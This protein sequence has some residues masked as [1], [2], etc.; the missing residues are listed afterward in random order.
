MPPKTIIVDYQGLLIEYYS[1][2]K[3]SEPLYTEDNKPVPRFQ[4]GIRNFLDYALPKLLNLAES[5]LNII[6]VEDRGSSFRRAMYPGYKQRGV[7]EPVRSEQIGL[8]REKAKDILLS[9]G[10]TF[11]SVPNAEADDVIAML[12]DRLKG[13]KQVITVDKDL[14]QLVRPGVKVIRKWESVSNLPIKDTELLLPPKWVALF[15]SLVGDTSDTYPGIKGFGLKAFQ[16][17]VMEFAPHEIDDLKH[18]VSTP[19]RY[20]LQAL[21]VKEVEGT[22]RHKALTLFTVN[23]DAWVLMYRLAK[24]YPETGLDNLRPPQ[25]S[26]SM[27]T[28]ENI[29]QA[30]TDAKIPYMAQKYID[31]FAIQRT[32]VTQENLS[33]CLEDIESLIPMSPCVPWDY[34]TT[35]VDK[36]YAN[37]KGKKKFVDTLNSKITGVSFAFGQ[38]LNKSYYFPIKHKDTRNVPEDL[39]PALLETVGDMGIELVAHNTSFE[40]TVSLCQLGIQLPSY[41]DTALFAHGADENNFVGLKALSLRYLKYKQASYDSL[42]GGQESDVEEEEDIT[43][44]NMED[45][46]G[47]QVLNYGCDDSLVTGRLKILF[48]F[49]AQVEGWYDHVQDNEPLAAAALAEITYSGIRID[50]DEM[51]KQANDDRAL[52]AYCETKLA[53]LLKDNLT[54][55]STDGLERY[56][57]DQRN[58]CKVKDSRAREKGKSSNSLSLLRDKLVPYCSYTPPHTN[59]IPY[60]FAYTPARLKVVTE[61]LG[62]PPIEKTTIKWVSSYLADL[63]SLSDTQGEFVTSL[64]NHI[65]SESPE[66]SIKDLEAIC[67]KHMAHLDKSEILGTQIEL[68]SNTF[69][70]ALLYVML[71][72]P[73]RVRAKVDQGT[74]RRQYGLEGSPSIDKSAVGFA[75]TLDC[76]DAPWKKEVLQT[77]AKYQKAAT[78]ISNYWESWQTWMQNGDCLHPYFRRFGTVTR[79]PSSQNPNFNSIDK[80]GDVRRAVIPPFDGWVVSSIDFS[81]QELRRLA[82]RCLDPNLVAG[83]NGLP[84]IDPHSF[85]ACNIAVHRLAI[86]SVVT[87]EDLVLT[88]DGL[89]DYDWF[90]ATRK[91]E[92]SV[93]GGYLEASRGV[94]KI[95]NFGIA[96]GVTAT[97][98]SEQTMLPQHI[99]E[100]AIKANGDSFPGI[101]KW[102][103]STCAYARDNGHIVTLFGMRR[104]CGS[105]LSVG[106]RGEISRWERQICNSDIQ[107]AC[108]DYLGYVLAECHRRNIFGIIKRVNGKPVLVQKGKYRAVLYN[109]LYDELLNCCHRDDYMALTYELIEIMESISQDDLVKQQVDC[110]VGLNWKDQHEVG[111]RPNAEEVTALFN[112]LFGDVSDIHS[113]A[114]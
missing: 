19:D 27:A 51:N 59:V 89:V 83:F 11:V 110:S 2:A 62:L 10:V 25:W 1:T 34:E 54:E 73:I 114:A 39:I 33:D 68:A 88:G 40:Y 72:L 85:V 50:L 102:Q 86:Q 46:T 55:V 20:A 79:R 37:L 70:S 99:A 103:K 35:D 56:L 94:A 47:L 109:A 106:S 95:V 15:L 96:Y 104:H 28:A 76:E 13:S 108:G 69:M 93:V 45:L 92:G 4:A 63:T 9:I 44:N 24:A 14:V 38:N 113:L 82:N 21:L 67:R 57:D 12:C 66:E 30:F 74:L 91:I 17:L 6:C 26:A 77:I 90:N 5:P 60:K 31:Q 36:R 32:L 48:N 52:V 29:S 49:I 58:Y 75:M 43:S 71:E 16:T 107:G 87:R 80:K 8:M 84:K 111:S 98:L 78:R 23:W 18:I 112:K 42:F 65:T 22:K 3:D 61:K 97:A 100:L 7:H 101:A 53:N 64:S 81:A 41:G 105:N